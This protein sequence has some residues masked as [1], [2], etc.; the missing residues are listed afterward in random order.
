MAIFRSGTPWGEFFLIAL[1]HIAQHGHLLDG[2]IRCK[3]VVHQQL[4]RGGKSFRLKRGSRTELAD[5]FQHCRTLF[6]AARHNLKRGLQLLNGRVVLYPHRT[7]CAPRG[8]NRSSR[9]SQAF[10]R[11]FRD[12]TETAQ[13]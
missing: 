5:P 13:H 8:G 4:D 12:R 9:G 11:G 2:V 7:D 1:R 10:E 3:V 6:G